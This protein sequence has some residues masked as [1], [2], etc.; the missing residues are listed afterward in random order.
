MQKKWLYFF[1]IV[2]SVAGGVWVIWNR[3][4]Y[5]ASDP[6][7]GMNACLFKAAT[8]LPCPSCGSTRAVLDITR[9]HFA[10]ALYANPLGFIIALAMIVFPFWILYDIAAR[11]QTFYNFYTTTEFVIRKRWVTVSMILLIA[12]NWVWNIYKYA[13]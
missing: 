13:S 1:V 8:G 12:A 4:Y 7:T 9:L 10:D 3:V 6:H 11:K 5:T 2:C